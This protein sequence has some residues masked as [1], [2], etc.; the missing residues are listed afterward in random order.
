MNI[1]THLGLLRDHDYR[2]L[3]ISTS[4]S[5]FGLAT[6]IIAM[7]LTAVLA[8]DASPMEM[9]L[10]AACQ[11]VAFLLI[12]LPAGA[13]VDRMR[14]RRVLIV[15]D[16]IRA[17]ALFTVPLAWAFDVLT[18]WQLYT[19][20][21]TFGSATVFFDVAYQSYLPHLVGRKNLVE[22]NSKLESMRAVSEVASPGIGGQ[23]VAIL[24]APFALAVSG[25]GIAASALF[26]V[27]IRKREPK[28]EPKP[29][30]HLGREIREGLVFVLANRMLRA[31]V[32]NT[33]VWVFSF[34]MIMSIIMLYFTNDLGLSPAAIGL[35][36]SIGG[37]GGIVGALVA[38]RLGTII[39]QGRIMWV[40]SLIGAPMVLLMAWA[41]PG[42]KLWVAVAGWAVVTVM[43]VVY[44]VTQVSF[45]QN[46][47]P[48]VLLGRMNATIRFIAWG[49]MPLGGL[50]GGALGEAFGVQTTMWIGGGC[51]CLAF[52]GTFFSPLR[53][54]KKFPTETV[55][56]PS[57]V[58]A[59]AP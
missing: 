40:S 31:I 36:M 22:G 58:K 21:V 28:P 24:T 38:R 16:F 44:N 41:E 35:I 50:V 6:T 13:W 43:I 7:P 54:M 18:M 14:R 37:C 32:I 51:L 27:G 56:V 30:A 15:C 26:V 10:L 5:H 11:T 12:G 25:V 42:W 2:G 48:D 33:T 9:G 55:P 4:A 1:R 59:P 29:D 23:L 17:G 57:L 20:A 52:L 19:V 3:F 45:R 39:G 49:T 53:N 34:T 46:I 47:T 8:L